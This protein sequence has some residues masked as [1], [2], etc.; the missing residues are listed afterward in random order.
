MLTNWKTIS[1]SI[2]RLRDLEELLGS[3]ESMGLT[4]KETLGLTREREKLERALGG[5]K[6]MGGLPDILFVIDTNKE[7]LAIQE[8]NKLGIPVVAVLDSNCSPDG[9]QFPIPGNDDALRAVSMYC[10]LTATS[11]LD[12]LQ[13]AM[14]PYG[15][16]IT[17]RAEATAEPA[18]A[19]AVLGQTRSDHPPA[20]TTRSARHRTRR[21]GG[22][23][24]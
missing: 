6:E 5:I 14:M 4:K 22:K 24:W 2:K 11:I 20:A 9:V 7:S 10:A 19:G 8:A 1:H 21:R 3:P 12:G 15:E 13:A 18:L 17:E 23:E 16:P